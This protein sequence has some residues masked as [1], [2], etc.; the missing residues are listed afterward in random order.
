[1][2]RR[3]VHVNNSQPALCIAYRQRQKHQSS[4]AS[5]DKEIN[6]RDF[7][8]SKAEQLFRSVDLHGLVFLGQFYELVCLGKRVWYEKNVYCF[9]NWIRRIFNAA[10]PIFF[11]LVMKR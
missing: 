4:N 6:A 9:A 5:A 2:D 8:Q 10:L 3:L 11:A 7:A 1:M